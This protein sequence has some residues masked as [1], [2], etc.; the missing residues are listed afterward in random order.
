MQTAEKNEFSELEIIESP[1]YL[2]SFDATAN[3]DAWNDAIAQANDNAKQRL[4]NAN[5]RVKA[6]SEFFALSPK[7][8]KASLRPDESFPSARLSIPR[9]NGR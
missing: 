2:P 9:S 3:L 4:A 7:L 5:Q 1:N 8:A 6:Q